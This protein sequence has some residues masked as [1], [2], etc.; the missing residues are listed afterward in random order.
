M[1][2]S[3]LP[4]GIVTFL[5][6]DIE[7]S[8]WLLQRLG[9]EYDQVVLDHRR[10]LR[11][12]WV[13]HG[14]VELGTEGD[15]FFVA[16]AEPSDAVNA[17]STGQRALAAHPWT[18]GRQVLVRMGIHTGEVRV[19]ND[20]YFGLAVHQ[21]A[22]VAGSA[23]GG[24][25]IVTDAT[26]ALVGSAIDDSVEFTELGLHRLKDLE[27]P[28][29]LFQLTLAG[30]SAVF[31]P[32][33][34]LTVMPNNFPVQ[35]TPFIGRED[36]VSG[37]LAALAEGS[38]VT[39]T[40]AGGIGK[41]RLALQ[42]AAEMIDDFPD[43]AWLVDLAGIADPDLVSTVAADALLV[44][45]QPGRDMADTLA[46]TLVSKQ[47]LVVLDNCEHLIDACA[48]LVHQLVS[49]CP[50]VK[51]LST[52]REALNIPGEVAWRVRSLT[53][54]EHPDLAM[55]RQA[56]AV[57]LFLQRAAAVRP[58]FVLTPDNVGAITQV[59]RRLDGLPLAIE[60]AA[61][62]VRSMTVSE[63]AVHLDDRF[64]LLTGGTRTALPRQRT[65]EA[66]VAWSYDLLPEADQTVFERLS[67]FAGGCT[68]AAAEVVCGSDDLDAVDVLNI[69]DRLVDRSLLVADPTAAGDTRY[70][71]LETLGQFGRER[72]LDRGVMQAI[73]ERHL[74]WAVGLAE[75][76]P[77]SVGGAGPDAAADE[78]NFRAAIEWASETGDTE[79]GLRICGSVWAG[80]F[81]ERRR[82]YER[83]LPPGPAVPDDVAGRALFAGG[84]L[85]F[86]MGD[87]AIGAERMHAAEAA[88][89]RSGN[90]FL[91]TMGMMYE[92]ACVWGLGDVDRARDLLDD[93][94]VKAE[95]AGHV[96][97]RCRGL[98]VRGWM[99]AGFDLGRAEAIARQGIELARDLPDA[100][101]LGHLME[102]LGFIHCLQGD[103]A[104][105]GSELADA[106]DLFHK[107]QQN[108]ASH[109]LETT[110]AWAAMALQFDV[111]AELWGAAE[112]MRDETKDKPRPWESAIQDVWLPAIR[113]AMSPEELRAAQQRGRQ[114]DAD[115]ALDH[116]ERVLRA[117]V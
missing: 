56:E 94:L 53:V 19:E 99:E 98:M 84:V 51:V 62:R 92:G 24:Q 115:G 43:G 55:A 28:I 54:P 88:N 17:A 57:R 9:E 70:R 5:F 36:D 68:L 1:S 110:A 113:S 29:R 109:M 59:C 39:L 65:L 114:L 95:A 14:G 106:T 25:V 85:A 75:T 87:W 20:D 100:F 4:R 41:T 117:G 7:G 40:G 93:G 104:Q 30:L 77:Q 83:L 96:G 86:M 107:I 66:A 61:A 42:A 11:D 27:Q 21:A 12:A 44:R 6:S 97:A 78:D 38:T 67:V 80:H 116:A 72:L 89:T 111:G 82:L 8:T 3:S 108:C 103:L 23:H 48:K 47:L 60:L 91:S 45:E 31:P 73:R 22:R 49:F 46:D 105:G 63:V 71:L 79:A 13:A 37:V 69:V 112:R 15:S 64:R 16:F 81:E 50:Q 90:A 101:D 26:R 52:S 18:H 32:P 76:L 33:R 2:G 10:L 34:T 35:A 58:D 102:L 74:T